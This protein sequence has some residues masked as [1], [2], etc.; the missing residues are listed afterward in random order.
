MVVINTAILVNQVTWRE[1]WLHKQTKFSEREEQKWKNLNSFSVTNLVISQ[2]NSSRNLVWLNHVIYLKLRKTLLFLQAEQMNFFHSKWP[3]MKKVVLLNENSVNLWI[4]SA[5]ISKTLFQLKVRQSRNV[6]F[7]LTILPKNEQTN[8]FIL[9]NSTKNEFAGSFLGRIRGYQK[10]L[11]K[12]ID[13][14]P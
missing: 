5:S 1:N 11:S 4:W 8:S 3:E 14:Y 9:P 7:K 2:Y 10:V 6:S 12:L 13:L